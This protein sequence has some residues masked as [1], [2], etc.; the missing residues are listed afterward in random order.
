MFYSSEIRTGTKTGNGGAQQV[1]ATHGKDINGSSIFQTHIEG[2]GPHEIEF[3]PQEAHA[4]APLINYMRENGVTI[5]M[6]IGMH[7]ITM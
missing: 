5:A 4:V 6:Y 3:L 7:D 1:S 2:R